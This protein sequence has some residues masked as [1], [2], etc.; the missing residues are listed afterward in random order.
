M[1]EEWNDDSGTATMISFSDLG[2][3]SLGLNGRG[4]M[5]W[6]GMDG[7]ELPWEVYVQNLLKLFLTLVVKTCYVQKAKVVY[8]TQYDILVFEEW[9]RTLYLRERFDAMNNRRKRSW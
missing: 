9:R 4:A 5:W 6:N 8:A 2:V 7:A 3:R 1:H